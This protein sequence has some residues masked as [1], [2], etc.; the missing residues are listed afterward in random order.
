MGPL[1]LPR[2]P[3]KKRESRLTRSVGPAGAFTV[4][5][6]VG[7]IAWLIP[8]TDLLLVRR[9]VFQLFEIVRVVDLQNKY[10]ALAVGFAV[11]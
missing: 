2:L 8:L 1:G 5:G 11:D 3:D 6:G 9:C 7:R 4:N 10:P